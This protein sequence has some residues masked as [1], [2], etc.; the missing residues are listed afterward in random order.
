MT[1]L[2]Y[3]IF[4]FQTSFGYS[5]HADYKIMENWKKILYIYIY[6]SFK[7]HRF[8]ANQEPNNSV[9]IEGNMTINNV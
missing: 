3:T 4:T 6:N 5:F 7:C 8:N 9:T 2:N 1:Y